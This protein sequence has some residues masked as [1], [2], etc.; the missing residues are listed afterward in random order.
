[1]DKRTVSIYDK[2][3]DEITIRHLQKEPIRL[4]ELVIQFFH[5]NSTTADIGCGS[6]R[7]TKWLLD[8]GYKAVGYDPSKG[9]LDIAKM[10]FP[11]VEF[12]HADLTAV[13]GLFHNILMCA[14]LMHIPR[15]QLPTSLMHL[16]S[17][18][19]PGGVAVLS[20]RGP[21]DDSDERRFENYTA[22]EIAELMMKL[23]C[24]ILLKE[25]DGIW[26]NIVIKREP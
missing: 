3:A 20:F 22:D 14:V 26:H 4:R 2:D 15:S 21:I 17:L 25:K 13:K 24:Q 12:Q 10:N 9:M 7:D 18:L 8:Q 5:P 23:G 19:Y 16:K 1:M 6:G 11:R